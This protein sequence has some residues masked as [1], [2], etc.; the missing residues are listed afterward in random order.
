MGRAPN[1]IVARSVLPLTVNGFYKA[2]QFYAPKY[3]TIND[4]TR[5]DL[6][7]T[8]YWQP[9]LMTDK[10]GNASFDFY[11]ADGTGQYQIIIE[12]INN[13]GTAGIAKL[14][15]EIKEQ[16]KINKL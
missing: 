16:M 2:R 4:H 8:I 9:E 13:K 3:D 12:G 6:R 15:Y 1:D 14:S 7:S 10:N 5:A 11:N